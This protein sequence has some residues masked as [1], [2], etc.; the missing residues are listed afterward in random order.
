[1]NGKGSKQRPRL[2]SHAEL[3]RRWE[4][5]FPVMDHRKVCYGRGCPCTYEEHHACGCVE[6][7]QG[8][9]RTDARCQ[10]HAE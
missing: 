3:Q 5:T 4:H 2:V 7:Y 8:D 6:H 9:K 10:L 1:M